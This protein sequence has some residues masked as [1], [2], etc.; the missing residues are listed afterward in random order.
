[1]RRIKTPSSS[2]TK[3]DDDVL[4]EFYGKIVLKEMVEKFDGRFT[5]VAI[6]NRARKLKICPSRPRIWKKEHVELL[7]SNYSIYHSEELVSLFDGQ[8]SIHQINYKANS[9]GLKKNYLIKAENNKCTI[10]RNLR[11]TEDD[12]RILV[13]NYCSKSNK[14]MIELLENRFSVGKIWEMA[15]RKGLYKDHW[16]KINKDVNYFR[17]INEKSA[18]V[19]GLILADGCLSLK[20]DGY[21]TVSISLHEDDVALLQKINNDMCMNGLGLI[22][23]NNMA[24]IYFN[25][26]EIFDSLVDLG[27]T[28]AKTHTAKFLY[29][30]SE[31]FWPDVVRGFTDGD[32]CV[33]D[34]SKYVSVRWGIASKNLADDLMGV[35]RGFGLH[36]TIKINKANS[37]YTVGIYGFEDFLKFREVV[38]YDSAEFFM[39][40]KKKRLDD[41]VERVNKS[42]RA[43][44]HDEDVEIVKTYYESLPN[45]IIAEKLGNRF[46]IRQILEKAIKLGLKKNKRR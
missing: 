37:F 6:N 30:I 41:L 43:R 28:P 38:Y 22:T 12:D 1:M 35:L 7:I 36:P 42:T 44:W 5:F 21:K 13:E 34:P 10:E 20:K 2:W 45:R 24:I 40:R 29:K 32:G 3:E 33:A 14:E 46:D 9:M 11:W 25:G 16:H 23:G 39:E 19:C 4:K 27:L 26:S 18:Y 8:Y 17:N 15:N 31:K